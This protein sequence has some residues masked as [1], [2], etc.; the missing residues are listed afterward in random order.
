MEKFLKAITLL[1]SVGLIV[2]VGFTFSEK[3]SSVFN[4]EEFDKVMVN[5][6][7]LLYHINHTQVRNR[8]YAVPHTKVEM[9]CPECG[10][11]QKAGTDELLDE[12]NGPENVKK[13]L[14]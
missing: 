9:Y 2:F 6:E 8:H 10:D 13:L 4:F 3:E 7:V 12:K 14:E 5:S 1:L 11:L